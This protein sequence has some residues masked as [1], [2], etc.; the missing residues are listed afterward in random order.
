MDNFKIIDEE[1]HL[2]LN[3]TFKKDAHVL[4]YNKRKDIC[5]QLKNGRSVN[6]TDLKPEEAQH[7]KDAL[8]IA[9]NYHHDRDQMLTH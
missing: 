6:T 5:M 8:E 4:I 2:F 9:I 3:W 1:D 7:Y